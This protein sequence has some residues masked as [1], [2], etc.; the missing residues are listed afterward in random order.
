M[1]AAYIIHSS[2]SLSLWGWILNGT[3]KLYP[4]HGARPMHKNNRIEWCTC[5]SHFGCTVVQA[6]ETVRSASTS[7]GRHPSRCGSALTCSILSAAKPI[8]H[9]S[10]TLCL[11][12]STLKGATELHP[13]CGVRPMKSK[14]ES[15][16]LHASLCKGEPPCKIHKTSVC[17]S[18]QRCIIN[19][20]K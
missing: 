20:T 3:M 13:R 16:Y 6:Q 4:S 2:M 10:V 12:Q 5:L 18:A 19:V 17:P 7:C 9:A 11:C 8:R 14:H 1:A 15:P